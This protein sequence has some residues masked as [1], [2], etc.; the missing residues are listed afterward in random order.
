L[1]YLLC[2]RED[3]ERANGHVFDVVVGMY[4]TPGEMH[5]DMKAAVPYI[6]KQV[7]PELR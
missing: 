2:N 3:T 6:S 5:E 7:A 4:G 1:Q